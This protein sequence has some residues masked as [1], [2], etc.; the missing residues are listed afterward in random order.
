MSL[1]M[2]AVRAACE[3][4]HTKPGDA[5]ASV[6]PVPYDYLRRE[7][8]VVIIRHRTAIT[9]HVAIPIMG[10]PVCTVLSEVDMPH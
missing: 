4:T 9:V 7:Y 8:V 2:Q 5:K 10:E 6:L 1:P 3:T